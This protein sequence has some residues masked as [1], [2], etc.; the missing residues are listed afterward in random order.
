MFE[1]LKILIRTG[2]F[3]SLAMNIE[4]DWKNLNIWG[5]CLFTD[6]CLSNSFM[7]QPVTL[8]PNNTIWQ[9]RTWSTLAQVMACCQTAPS[10]YLNQSWIIISK[11]QWKSPQPSVTNTNSKITYRRYHSNLPGANELKVFTFSFSQVLCTW[12]V[13]RKPHVCLHW[14]GDPPSLLTPRSSKM[15]KSES[16]SR[17]TRRS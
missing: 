14:P 4:E 13:V 6:S 5:Q 9:H 10:H 2:N 16:T 12:I 1:F 17:S 11:V 7:G 3:F 8:W 15:A